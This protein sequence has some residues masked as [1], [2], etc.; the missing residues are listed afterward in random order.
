M[1]DINNDLSLALSDYFMNELSES[2]ETES[3]LSEDTKEEQNELVAEI[4]PVDDLPPIVVQSIA[5]RVNELAIAVND[6]MEMMAQHAYPENWTTA[7]FTDMQ[8][9]NGGSY[10][11]VAYIN[12]DT[13]LEFMI[14]RDG[15]EYWI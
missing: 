9:G 10:L 7:S 14:E 8:H 13:G 11:G 6:G 2:D 4:T 5:D 15:K 3:D 12:S 1:I